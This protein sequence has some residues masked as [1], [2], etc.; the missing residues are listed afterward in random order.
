LSAN[1]N[2]PVAFL[3]DA[4]GHGLVFCGIEAANHGSG[5]CE[6]DLML[7]GAPA[8]KNSHP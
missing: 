4:N 1:A 6:G 8:K 2:A 3:G 5:G 7:A